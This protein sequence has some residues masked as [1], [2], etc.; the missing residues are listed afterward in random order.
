VV[1]W[2]TRLH[3][4]PYCLI[5]HPL[6]DSLYDHQGRATR[7]ELRSGARAARARSSR[8]VF[9]PGLTATSTVPV[10]KAS[11]PRHD[12]PSLAEFLDGVDSRRNKPATAEFA[13]SVLIEGM[14]QEK[15]LISSQVGYEEQIVEFAQAGL[16][17]LALI[18]GT[19]T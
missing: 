8:S 11:P 1:T 3:R 4:L 13:A 9:C 5:R 18:V 7:N 10:A 6:P 17:P 16:D 12:D 19:D 2:S 15:F 14:R